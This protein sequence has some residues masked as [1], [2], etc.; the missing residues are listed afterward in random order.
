MT[1]PKSNYVWAAFS[2]F[3]MTAAFPKIDFSWCAWF[4]LVPLLIAIRDATP[5][6]GFLLA[7]IAGTVHY[8]GLLYWLVYTMHTYGYLPIYQ[9]VALLLVMA[10][11]LSIFWGCF[12]WF[13]VANIHSPSQL[14]LLPTIW[15]ALEYIRTYLL[16]G[17]PWGFLGHSQYKQIWIIQIADLIGVY[18]IT[19]LLVSIN[20]AM[21]MCFAS[22]LKYRWKGKF[23]RFRTVFISI[24]ASGLMIT[25]TFYYGQYRI[26]A[27]NQSLKKAPKV[28]I[29]LIQGNIDQSIKWDKSF[30]NFTIKRYNRLSHS[31][32]SDKPQLIVW[33]ETATPFYFT[34]D[35][36]LTQKVMIG[37]KKNKAAFLI[38]SPSVTVKN[39]WVQYYNS[40]YL[41][42]KSGTTIGKYDKVHLVP[43]GEYVP[44]KKYLAFAGKMVEQ[45]GD[46]RSGKKGNILHW[47]DKKLGLQICYEILFPDLSRA[48]VVNGADL[49][50]NITNDAWFGTTSAAYQNFAM[51]VF[52]AV[53]NKRTLARSANTGI[54]GF[55]DPAGRI[56]ATTP[57]FEEK[58]VTQSAPILKETTVYSRFGDIFASTCLSLM[59]II[60]ISGFIQASIKRIIRRKKN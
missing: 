23:I 39:G 46:F 24:L 56:L 29:A 33:P 25:A 42:D 8:I 15:T 47:K 6:Q 41:I 12:G 50:I 16:T 13:T 48:M 37:V 5:R 43:F 32:L 44:L 57:L 40:A 31:S 17:F 11:Y 58:V 10:M 2:G 60:V 9:S 34:Y 52:R 45:V 36:E 30:Q 19:F 26:N 3:L 38:G 22:F 51:A 35:K 7:M 28:K 27:V 55:V 1:E 54:S 21:F 4:A 53:E 14:W 49:L 18:G 59:T 20:I